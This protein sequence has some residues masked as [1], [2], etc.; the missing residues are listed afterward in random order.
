VTVLAQNGPTDLRLK[1]HLVVLAAVVADDVELAWRIG[2]ECRLLRPASG[3]PL[4]RHHITL[5]KYLLILFR[6]DKDFSALNTRDLDV[7][8]G[9][10]SFLSG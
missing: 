4:R 8:H 5:V 1:R 2:P 6:K 3:T 10:V 9:I 7:R